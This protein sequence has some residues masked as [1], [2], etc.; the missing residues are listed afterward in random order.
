ML[1]ASTLASYLDTLMQI[2][3]GSL[4][5]TCRSA[6]VLPF[7]QLQFTNPFFEKESLLSLS[8]RFKKS[9]SASNVEP[10]RTRPRLGQTPCFR[11]TSWQK[12]THASGHF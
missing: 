1:G 12:A 6:G 8:A 3:L 11:Y 7:L 10:G 4:V 5:R 2:A 9:F